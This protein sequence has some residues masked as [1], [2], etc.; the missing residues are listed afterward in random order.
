MIRAGEVIGSV[1]SFALVWL[2]LVG[3]DPGSWILGGPAVLL[4]VIVSQALGRGRSGSV[5]LLGALYFVPY[6]LV[7]S[8]VSGLDVLRR[9]FALK[10][11]INPGLISYKTS[12]P[13]EGPRVFLANTISLMPGTL[14]VDL[15]GELIDV[16][17]LDVDKPVHSGIR[18]LEVRI[19]HLFS[20]DSAGRKK[21]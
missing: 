19:A 6:F 18:K 5:S 14:S 15:R 11:N 1:L 12:L 21:G 8:T 7:Q 16:H 2:V 4:A 3:D 20:L 10:P 13:E 9:T 17:T